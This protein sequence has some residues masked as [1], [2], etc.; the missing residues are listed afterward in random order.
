[1]PKQPETAEEWVEFTHD[2]HQRQAWRIRQVG[3]G[4]RM[5]PFVMQ[6]MLD[7]EEAE[8]G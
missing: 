4:V 5:A 8:G 3:P 1:M 7:S 6:V 2:V